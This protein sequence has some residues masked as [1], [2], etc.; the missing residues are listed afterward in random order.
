VESV[1]GWG[2]VKRRVQMLKVIELLNWRKA[3]PKWEAVSLA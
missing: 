3:E 2:E 1:K